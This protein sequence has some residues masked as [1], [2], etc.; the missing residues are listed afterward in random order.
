MLTDWLTDWLTDRQMNGQMDRL[1]DRRM[2]KWTDWLTVWLTDCLTDWLAGWLAGW[3]ADRPSNRLISSDKCNLIMA[4]HSYR[5]DFFTNQCRFVPRRA[6]FPTAP[7]P[8]HAS[9]FYQSLPLFSRIAHSFLH[10]HVDND[11]QY[12]RH[13]F[14]VKLGKVQ[15]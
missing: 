9:W 15:C 2:D 12:S 1:T 11:L 13:A 4:I 3:L 6:F 5:L 8:M 7:T 10:Y 14:R